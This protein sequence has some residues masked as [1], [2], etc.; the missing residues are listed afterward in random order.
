[1]SGVARKTF[2]AAGVCRRGVPRVVV[3]ISNYE[4]IPDGCHM[5]TINA[6]DKG[7]TPGDLL[8]VLW[9]GVFRDPMVLRPLTAKMFKGLY[10]RHATVEARGPEE[11]HTIHKP[12]P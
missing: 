11:L 1:M 5:A 12:L 7:P 4:Q 10:G 9:K 6:N 2:M 3:N 8:T